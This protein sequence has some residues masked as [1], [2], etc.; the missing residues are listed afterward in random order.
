MFEKAYMFSNTIKDF[1]KRGIFLL[2]ALYGFGH[3]QYMVTMLVAQPPLLHFL[4]NLNKS[5]AAFQMLHF[6]QTEK[7][8]KERNRGQRG[9][10]R[11]KDSERERTENVIVGYNV[12]TYMFLL[13][14]SIKLECH[15][16]MCIM[17]V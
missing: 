17:H 13:P 15:N 3:S 11:G 1:Q 14:Q 5:I 7:R 10:Q 2:A 9:D 12:V 6:V 16:A 8:H 4:R